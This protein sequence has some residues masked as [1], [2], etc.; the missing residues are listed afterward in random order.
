MKW[1]DYQKEIFDFN[2]NGDG[3]LFVDAKAGSG[4]STVVKKC[5]SD[6]P[7]SE[8]I[9][10]AAFSKDIEIPLKS[11]FE[12]TPN[13]HVQTIHA[14]GRAQHIQATGY[15]R[16]KEWKVSNILRYKVLDGKE[17]LYKKLRY[18]VCRLISLF[19]GDPFKKISEKRVE[20]LMDDFGIDSPDDVS[21]EQLTKIVQETWDENFRR[22]GIID[23]DDMVA[24]PL[25]LDQPVNQFERVYVDE[26]QDLSPAQIALVRKAIQGR[27]FFVG[28]PRQAIYRFRGAD[29]EA[30]AKIIG[31]L[32]CAQL[33][34][35]VSYRC[36]KSIVK[37]AQRI[38]PEIEPY[39]NNPEGYV[40]ENMKMDDFKN[41][42]A[43]GDF[44]L[45]RC[46]APLVKLCLS[47]I[48][49]GRKAGVRG[50]GIEETLYS[51]FDRVVADPGN[52]VQQL[53]EHRDRVL[54]KYEGKSRRLNVLED[55]VDTLL[56]ILEGTDPRTLK[57]AK[58]AIKKVFCKS[59]TGITLSTIHKAKG[60]ES[61]NVYVISPELLPHP[62]A[63]SKKDLEAEDNLWYVA[64]TRAK[65]KLCFVH[66]EV[67]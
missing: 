55:Q 14:F 47:F 27:G 6:S 36:A 38:V 17:K 32:G 35:S 39:E 9:L 48:R 40:D 62:R 22:T 10:V 52:M 11:H 58:R 44:V 53:C 30:V 16:F 26:A 34:L 8:E 43:D 19:K 7:G 24:M 29:R 54:T 50:R 37:L 21:L 15:T 49:Q 25:V 61:K 65:E 13:A 20:F 67:S 63:K 33:P 56:A 45:G 59:T 12:S 31:G 46:N 51:L 4:K 3:N 23:F 18:A 1:S 2:I 5:V 57:E 41:Q 64:V 60:L 28:D 66:G 42:V